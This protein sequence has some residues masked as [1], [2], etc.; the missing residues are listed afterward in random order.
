[1]KKPEHV[2]VYYYIGNFKDGSALLDKVSFQ[3]RQAD[4]AS[5]PIMSRLKSYWQHAVWKFTTP[6][7]RVVWCEKVI[8]LP[9]E[10]SATSR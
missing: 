7:A 8:L 4:G 9:E 10:S 1:M 6:K 2:G 3:I 5:S